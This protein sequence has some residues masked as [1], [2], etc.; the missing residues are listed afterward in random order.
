MLVKRTV[1]WSDYHIRCDRCHQPSVDVSEPDMARTIAR[2]AGWV[3]LR[4]S[5]GEIDLC[6]ACKRVWSRGALDPLDEALHY[7]GS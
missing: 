3:R 6:P 1:R 7:S 5:C 4:T 2:R